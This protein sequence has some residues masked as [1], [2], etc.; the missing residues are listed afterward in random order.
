MS[1]KC[2]F[3]GEQNDQEKMVCNCGYEYSDTVASKEGAG[4][5]GKRE[6]E[7]SNVGVLITVRDHSGTPPRG[8]VGTGTFTTKEEGSDKV[9]YPLLRNFVKVLLLVTGVGMVFFFISETHSSYAADPPPAFL[10]ILG[11]FLSIGA[12]FALVSPFFDV[13]ALSITFGERGITYRRRTSY[14]KEWRIAY[15]DVAALSYQTTVS[16]RRSDVGRDGARE[17]VEDE[18]STYEAGMAR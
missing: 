16:I 4:I 15:A 18:E 6:G 10:F 3:C 17:R 2:P 12:L 7:E 14:T 1:W 11:L 9:S 13:K 8:T 5:E